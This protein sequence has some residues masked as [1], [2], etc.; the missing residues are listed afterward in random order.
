M[1]ALTVQL[2]DEVANRLSALAEAKGVTLSELLERLT[3]EALASL[4]VEA[5][6]KRLAQ[7]DCVPTALTILDRLDREDDR[8]AG[9]SD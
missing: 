8:A 9:I 1:T 2:P 4:E 6:F 5:A 7:A 3:T